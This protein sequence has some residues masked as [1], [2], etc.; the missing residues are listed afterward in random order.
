M[1]IPKDGKDWEKELLRVAREVV[2][3]GWGEIKMV[4]AKPIGKETNVRHITI[5][6]MT[7]TRFEKEI[8][9]EEKENKPLTKSQS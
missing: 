7:T 8:L 1:A 6:D 9:D 4:V 3:H 2:E 5:S